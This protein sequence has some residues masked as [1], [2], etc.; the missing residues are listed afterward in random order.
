MFLELAMK[1]WLAFY[2][3]PIKIIKNE[4][5]GVCR[6]INTATSILDV[7]PNS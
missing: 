2:F 5:A 6:Y 7:V 1:E 4:Y 3:S